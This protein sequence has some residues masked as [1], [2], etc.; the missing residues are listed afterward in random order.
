MLTGQGKR[1][2]NTFKVG[3]LNAR[4]V[5]NKAILICDY[6]LDHDFDIFCITESWL[7]S[8]EDPT[9]AHLIPEG[10]DNH[11]HV[12]AN[13]TGGGIIII[14]KEQL[15]LQKVKTI[16]FKSFEHLEVTANYSNNLLRFICLY[17]RPPSSK[18]KL[19]VGMF[20]KEFAEYIL[21]RCLL[22]GKMILMGD[23]NFHIDDASDKN[24]EEFSKL[25]ESVN[26]NQLVNN[27]THMNGHIL[28]LIITHKKEQ[29][30]SSL[31]VDDCDISDHSCIHF[32]LNLQKP[33]AEKKKVTYRKIRKINS[34]TL[35]KL[36]VD[37]NVTEKVSSKE[38]VHDKVE[39]FNETVE[40]VLDLL[41]PV[42]TKNVPIRPN[43]HWYTDELRTLKQE[44]RCAERKW[45][46]SRLEIHRQIYV[47][48]KNKVND[49]LVKSKKKYFKERIFESKGNS[50]ELYKLVKSLYKP[51]SSY[52]PVL[53]SHDDTEQLCNNFSSFFG[54]KIDNIRNQL[55]SESTLT[56]N[57]EPP[58]NPS[59]TLQEF[60]PALVEEV[61]KLI[62]A[63][64]NKSCVLDKI[65]AWLFKEAHKELAPSLADIINSSLANH[66]FPSSLKQAYVTPLIKKA[67]LDK[68]EMKN[69]RPV[70][71]I[72]IISKLIE[73]I[74]SSR[75]LQH[76]AFNNL[77]TNFQSAYKKHH[78]TESALLRVANDILRY[79]DNK[80][81]VLLILLDLSAAFD[82]IDHEILLA[83]AHSRFGIDGKAL[84]W[85]N[86]YL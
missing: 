40:A 23:F 46:K 55:D 62:I 74:V 9:L 54:G 15:K 66:D 59:S 34:D 48:A 81:S 28:D 75:I 51:T 33:K 56:P 26:L 73:K 76:L 52:K 43:S 69:Y 2:N 65:P 10:Y 78:S 21:E 53:P 13:R 79:I 19:N 50:N 12:R 35:R 86:A 32:D 6:I 1:N 49:M 20:M 45:R 22:S 71:N 44:R 7:T 16:K 18:N 42:K 68:E 4:S 31:K 57:N 17:R 83:R 64:P 30:V 47:Y 67:S 70:S 11:L 3:L 58:S 77:H 24:A 82:T 39:I 38:T 41:A 25:I 14:F 61:D 85:L 29:I 37:S 84:Y 63:M 5:C 60:R 72:P 27:S 36:I 80:K 8:E